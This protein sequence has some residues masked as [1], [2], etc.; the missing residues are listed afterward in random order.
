MNCD[1]WSTLNSLK[2]NVNEN[3]TAL[4]MKSEQNHGEIQVSDSNPEI[5]CQ[6]PDHKNSVTESNFSKYIDSPPWQPWTKTAFT[7]NNYDLS[8]FVLL[9]WT[10]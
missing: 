6:N 4:E 2:N 10:T 1:K 8:L 3:E 9:Y 7:W 5:L